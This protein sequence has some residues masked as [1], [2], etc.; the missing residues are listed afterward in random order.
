MPY[1]SPVRVRVAVPSDFA[2]PQSAIQTSP[3]V[4]R[5]RLLGF[6]SRQHALEALARN[7]LH[8]EPLR[9]LVHP[10]AEDRH[11]VGMVQ[12]RRGLELAVEAGD[13]ALVERRVA[14]KDL[15]RDAAIELVVR[16]LEDDSRPAAADESEQTEAAESLAG[17]TLIPA[18]SGAPPSIEHSISRREP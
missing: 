14:R 1:V 10:H 11:D 7:E 9:A 6:T 3:F 17:Q 4:S 15:E 8:R 16:R 2:S 12:S 13:L 18:A 5:S